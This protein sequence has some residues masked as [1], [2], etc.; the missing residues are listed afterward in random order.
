MADAP[1]VS[2]ECPA[3]IFVN[4]SAGRGYA[5]SCLS[6]IQSRFREL[7]FPAEFR[8]TRDKEELASNVQ[9]AIAGKSKLLIAM[10]G[11]GTF[12]GLANAAFG[13]DVI[14]GILPVGGGNDFAGAIGL[15]CDPVLATEA[16]LAGKVRSVDMVRVRTADGKARLYCGGGGVGLDAEA[17]KHA[18]GAFRHLPG[19]SRYIASALRA[20]AAYTSLDLRIEFPETDLSPVEAKALLACVLNTP[21]YGAGLKLAPEARIDDG[22]LSVVLIEGLGTLGILALLP[23]LMWS[24]ELQTSHVKR[25]SARR[26]HLST[27]QPSSFHGDGEILGPTPVVVEV[28]PRAIRVLA[29]FKGVKYTNP[30]PR[31][32]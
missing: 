17:A 2:R 28:V 27:C 23:R 9:E 6:A 19:R 3:V 22:S 10:G 30:S 18:S 26:V 4:R 8:E 16:L 1:M 32:L 14:L 21:T 13:A 7:Q 20:L 31:F 29:P 25:W 12:Q 11:D 24:G 5:K 15:P